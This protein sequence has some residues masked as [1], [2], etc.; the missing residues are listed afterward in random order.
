MTTQETQLK[1]KIMKVFDITKQDFYD[2]ADL[3]RKGDYLFY[4]NLLNGFL[5]EN[6]FSDLRVG[7]IIKTML[8]SFMNNGKSSMK[9]EWCVKKAQGPI[10]FDDVKERIY[11]GEDKYSEFLFYKETGKTAIDF[12]KYI[13]GSNFLKL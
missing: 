12:I 9:L 1:D 5:I 10:M 4:Q 8:N 13:K 11:F 7:Q 6:E 2:K 3:A